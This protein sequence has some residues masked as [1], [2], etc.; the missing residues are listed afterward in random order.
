MGSGQEPIIATTPSM[1]KTCSR[2]CSVH[3]GP[4]DM[5]VAGLQVA[6]RIEKGTW[7]VCV[8]THLL[9]YGQVLWY[10]P[11]FLCELLKL[12]QGLQVFLGVP[13]CGRG[14]GEQREVS[15]QVGK[16][17]VPQTGALPSITGFITE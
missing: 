10:K 16:E 15:T 13:P 2:A 1:T 17:P 7:V 14:M 9:E 5:R 8:L 11:P 12:F 6:Q 4:G 3:L